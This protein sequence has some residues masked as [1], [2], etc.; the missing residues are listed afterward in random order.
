MF[1]AFDTLCFRDFLT[2][3]TFLLVFEV[4]FDFFTLYS[5][6]LTL[7]YWLISQMCLENMDSMQHQI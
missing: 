1:L 2:G 7:E 6:L 5:S 4:R 3:K